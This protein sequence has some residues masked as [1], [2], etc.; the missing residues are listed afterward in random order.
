MIADLAGWT[1]LH[2]LWQGAL[3]AVALKGILAAWGWRGPRFR[4]LCTYGA[5]LAMLTIPLVTALA[6]GVKS[7]SHSRRLGQTIGVEFPATVTPA[8]VSVDPGSASPA[9]VRLYEAVLLA[10]VK[11]AH[12]FYLGTARMPLVAR[13][14]L[15]GLLILS[16]VWLVS[17]LRLRR[18]T[19]RST[20]EWPDWH[21]RLR[22]LSGE[23]RLQRPVG[24]AVLPQPAMPMLVGWRRPTIVLPRALIQELPTS[25]TES[26]LYHELMHV[27]RRDHIA[28]LVQ[29]IA[30]TL[31]FFNPAVWWVSHRMRTER[32]YC[33]DEAVVAA[34]G[35]RSAYAQGLAWLDTN[36]TQGLRSAVSANGG[37]TLQRLRRL[38]NH[39]LDRPRP[40]ARRLSVL[41]TVL[42][43][44]AIPIGL[45]ILRPSNAN[46]L[47][48][49]PPAQEVSSA[50]QT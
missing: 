45:W 47:G 30:E 20:G 48:F 25:A 11:I 5:L 32:E 34:L 31:L 15:S 22:S 27:K 12:A 28:N 26:L 38:A 3:I 40:L 24:L 37:L 6:I 21:S 36:S 39:D 49:R 4:Y 8:G 10:E 7:D 41:L 42:A 46:V 14:W 17:A 2:F 13:L 29:L 50:P 23:L 18:L 43:L 19:G 9:Q 16:G 35:K 44:L 33:C 1:L